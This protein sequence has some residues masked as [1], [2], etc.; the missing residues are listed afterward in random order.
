MN[1][2]DVTTDSVPATAKQKIVAAM[3][4]LDQPATAAEIAAAAAIGYSTTTPLLR[5]ML[6][7]GQ[8]TKTAADDGR[9]LWHL[10]LAAAAPAVPA[11]GPTQA[12]VPDQPDAAVDPT[13]QDTAAAPVPTDGEPTAAEPDC[14]PP[15]SA[16]DTTGSDCDSGPAHDATAPPSADVDATTGHGAVQA[17]ADTPAARRQYSKPRHQRRPPGALPAA[18]LTVVQAEPERAFTVGEICKRIDAATTGQSANPA[19]AGAVANACDK[20]AGSGK[21]TR[22]DGT[23]ARYQAAG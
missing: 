15:C 13:E 4:Q 9:T 3:W 7:A 14:E 21:L 23:P 19:G 16:L 6:G 5:T 18:V 20:L 8:V 17:T 1:P 12:Q 22:V 11:D 2:P 10:N